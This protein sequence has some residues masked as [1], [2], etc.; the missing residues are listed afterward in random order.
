MSTIIMNIDNKEIDVNNERIDM[1][2][3]AKN[4]PNLFTIKKNK[5]KKFIDESN[6]NK[7]TKDF[8]N[9]CLKTLELFKDEK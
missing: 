7:I 8:L 6:K 2:V 4:E 3:L 1:A 5:A 9:A